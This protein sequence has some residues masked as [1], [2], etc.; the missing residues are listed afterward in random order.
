MGLLALLMIVHL[1]FVKLIRASWLIGGH[2]QFARKVVI[3]SIDIMKAYYTYE[4]ILE[5]FCVLV[6]GHGVNG[7][8]LIAIR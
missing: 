4:F 2:K 8:L 1:I 6:F 7:Y 5:M 3:P